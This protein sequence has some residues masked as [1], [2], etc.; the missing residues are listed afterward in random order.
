MDR[1]SGGVYR[2]SLPKQ[3]QIFAADVS[4]GGLD[5]E[6]RRS[7]FDSFGPMLLR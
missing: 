4:H 2:K 3:L 5:A 7:P 6:S 1:F